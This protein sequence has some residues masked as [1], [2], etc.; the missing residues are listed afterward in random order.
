MYDDCFM[1]KGYPGEYKKIKIDL[2]ILK[3]KKIFLFFKLEQN[4][5]E[6]LVSSGGRVLNIVAKGQI[7]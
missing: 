5:K 7:F 2:K 4:F 6:D 1:S 3:I